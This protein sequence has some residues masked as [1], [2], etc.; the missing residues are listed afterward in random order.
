MHSRV[1]PGVLAMTL[2]VGISNFA[3]QHP[4]GDWLTWAAFTFPFTFL[5][6]DLTNR[7]FG[8]SS[9]R[10]VVYAGFAFG[11]LL[12][13]LLSTPRIA[14]ASGTAFLVS[15]LL[16]VAVFHRLRRRGRWW[17]AP[18]AS[19]VLGSALD[20]ALFFTL[21]FA[22]TDLPWVTLAVGDLGAKYLFALAMLGF[23]RVAIPALPVF[24]GDA[25]PRGRSGRGQTRMQSLP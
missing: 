6:T 23:Y 20:T 17:Y 12:S 1:L 19:S 5:I 11:V 15:Q 16:N 24:G 7:S 13:I 2:V 3:V 25:R 14:A 21:A 9:A 10:I 8:P 4:L 22:G 18:L